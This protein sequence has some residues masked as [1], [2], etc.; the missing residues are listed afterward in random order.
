MNH[1]LDL[2]CSGQIL[3][4]GLS[5]RN[6]WGHWG[7]GEPVKTLKKKLNDEMNINSKMTYD[8]SYDNY[9]NDPEMQIDNVV[10]P[11]IKK[12]ILQ[13]ISLATSKL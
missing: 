12:L 4:R 5:G 13:V 8:H 10:F 9:P 1:S 2:I 7:G 6:H 3:L 11:E